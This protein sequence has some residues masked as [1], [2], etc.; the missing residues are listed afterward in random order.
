LIYRSNWIIKSKI[1]FLGLSVLLL[2][3]FV[4][5]FSDWNW[6]TEPLIVLLYFPLLVALGA[7]ATLKQGFKKLC[8][9]SG[10][11]SYPLYMTHYAVMWIFANY[12]TTYK[13]D[14]TQLV[15]I[16]AIGTILLVGVAYLTMVFYDIP[17][18]KYL[19]NRRKKA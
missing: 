4:T 14:T 7:G 11:I 3:A 6:L 12:Y 18:R 19:T 10:K 2:L 16:M 13:P 15:F 9:F 8:V 1:G 5:P 17:I